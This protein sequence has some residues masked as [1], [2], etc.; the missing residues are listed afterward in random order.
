MKTYVR[1]APQRTSSLIDSVFAPGAQRTSSRPAVDIRE[2]EDRYI[3]DAEFPGVSE[4]EV[5]I[6][7]EENLLTISSEPK[8]EKTNEGYLVRER[9]IAPTKRSFVLPKDVDRNGI[10]ARFSNGVLTIELKKAE[11]AKPR[12]IEISSN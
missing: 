12:R 8:Q 7:V 3:L 2:T 5:E 6:Q 4:G 11:S 1:Y 10:E 9:R